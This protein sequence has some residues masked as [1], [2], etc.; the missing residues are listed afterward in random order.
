MKDSKNNK[1][2]G[3]IKFSSLIKI[4]ILIVVAA[5]I[6]LGSMVT[7]IVL[8]IFKKAP[9]IEP[10]EYRTQLSETSRIYTND[11]KLIESLV[12]DE[13]SEFVPYEDIPKDLVNAIVAIEDERFFE[14]SGVDYRRVVGAL[15]HDIKTR[16]FDQGA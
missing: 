1:A 2:R 4:L 6:I 12:S 16:S 14:H 8:G 3:M 10:S 7:A 15:V 11:G 5:I 13:F 9:V